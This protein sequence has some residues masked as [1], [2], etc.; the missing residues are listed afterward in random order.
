MSL[1]KI[2]NGGPKY[3]RETKLGFTLHESDVVVNW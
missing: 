1:V 3:V 2:K